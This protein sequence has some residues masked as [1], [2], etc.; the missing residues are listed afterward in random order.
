MI[1]IMKLYYRDF[2]GMIKVFGKMK[3]RWFWVE[4][5]CV[6]ERVRERK[7]EIERLRDWERSG[8]KGCRKIEM[9][10]EKRKKRK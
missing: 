3:V 2:V 9:C 5:V 10:L 1:V 4:I 6:R 8:L 7:S